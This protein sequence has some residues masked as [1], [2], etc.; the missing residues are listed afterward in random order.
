[1]AISKIPPHESLTDGQF[2]QVAGP[3]G[4]V[5]SYHYDQQGRALYFKESQVI[6]SGQHGISHV[7]EDPVPNAT[8]DTPGLMSADDKAKLD[9]LIGTRIGVA[10]FHGSGFCD[11][12]GWLDGDIILTAGTEFVS[13]ERIGNVIRWVVDSPIP[14]NCTCEG[15]TQIF[16]VQDETDIAAMRPPTCS[17]KLPGVNAYGELKVYLFPESTVADPNNA[18]ATLQNKGNYPALVFKRYDDALVPGAAEHEMILKRDNSLLTEI[19]WAFTP[20]AVGVPELVY[21]MGKDDDGNQIRFDIEPEADPQLLGS[22]LYNGHLITKKMGVI[23]NYTSSIL[24][25]NQYTVRQWNTDSATAVGDTFTARNVWQYNNPENPPSGTNAKTL[26]TDVSIDLLPIG[27]IVDLWAFKIGE[28]GGEPILRWYFSQKPNLNAENLWSM[29][30]QQQ[31]GDVVIAREELQP[32]AGETDKEAAYQVSAIRDFERKAWG[33]TGY[34]DPV[35]SYAIASTEGTVDADLTEQHRAVIDTALPGLKVQASNPDVTHF[36]E[37]PVYLWN[38][39]SISNAMISMDIGRPDTSDFVPYDIILRGHIDENETKYLQVTEKGVVD[40]LHYIRVAGVHFHDIP[41]FGTLRIVS[42]GANHNLIFN[43]TRKFL[44]PQNPSTIILSNDAL[45]NEEYVGQVGD[46]VELLHQE[47]NNPVI[48][49][50]FLRDSVTGAVGLQFKVGHLDM[51][52][53]YEGDTSDDVDDYV[54]GLAPGYTVSAEYGQVDSF[55]GVGT[56]PESSVEGFVIYNGGAQIGGEQDEY[57]NRLEV[58]VRDEQVWIWWNKLLIPP[59]AALSANLPTP[60]SVD[61]PY[62]P[63]DMG[64]K[65]FGKYGCRLWPGATVRRLSVST[66]LK[67]ASEFQYGQL[68]VV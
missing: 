18:S 11:D 20:G 24:S 23:T 7:A 4:I 15:C 8:Y 60:V 42:P 19:G 51:G 6:Y 3:D 35:L 49:L 36:S 47:Y 27:T 33:I 58:M 62:F 54:R 37:R 67:S 63:I 50:E 28:S 52:L 17:G 32:D 43:Y 46:L 48:R 16:W 22:I 45:N 41:P 30:G 10:G 68:T 14:L 59:S 2:V 13:I 56:P 65:P 12:G 31:F 21:F 40:G 38:R 29:V 66:Q 5:T 44:D 55:T 25:T 1:M 61:T 39:N 26:I 53:P 57:W 34:D 64:G 9:S